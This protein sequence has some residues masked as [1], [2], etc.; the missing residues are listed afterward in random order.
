MG[1][2]ANMSA[3]VNVSR[4][5]TEN[6]KYALKIEMWLIIMPGTYLADFYT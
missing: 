6:S 2:F 4:F 5:Y 3:Y 1:K